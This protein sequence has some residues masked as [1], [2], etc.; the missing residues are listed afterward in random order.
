MKEKEE[1]KRK[2]KTCTP[3]PYTQKRPYLTWHARPSARTRSRSLVCSRCVCVP[4][5]ALL[6]APVF[7]LYHS[8]SLSLTHTHTQ[9]HTHTHTHS[10]T[11]SL[12]LAVCLC[13]SPSTH[14]TDLGS[15]SL[16]RARALSLSLSLSHAT[17]VGS[18]R[19]LSSLSRSSLSLLSPPFLSAASQR[20]LRP[21]SAR[22]K[23]SR[24]RRGQRVP[25]AGPVGVPVCG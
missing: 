2:R 5:A 12:Y 17:D 13:M 15:L 4:A 21:V 22:Q 25:G 19:L 10:L 7:S 9:T 16:S 8:L 6:Y 11:L 1:K 14:A 20:D 3:A 23:H 18:A 24:Q